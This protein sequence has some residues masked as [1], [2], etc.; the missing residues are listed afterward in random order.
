MTYGDVIKVVATTLGSIASGGVVVLALAGWLG[1]VWANRIM[2]NDRA[3]HARLLEQM[4][5]DAARSLEAQR[6][7]AQLTLHGLKERSD[8][9]VKRLD[10]ELGR[11]RYVHSMQFKKEFELYEQTWAAL[12]LL[13]NKTLSLRPVLDQHD[14]AETREQR[15]ERRLKEF[16]DAFNAFL[17]LVSDHEPFFPEQVFESINALLRA[18]RMEAVDY[19]LR[20][21][22]AWDPQY[23]ERQK[24]NGAEILSLVK[25]IATAIRHRI[26]LLSASR[27]Q[28]P[29]PERDRGPAGDGVPSV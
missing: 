17:T 2:E 4:K 6:H 19:E 25:E 14:P 9:L 13:R 20:T 23:W 7:D 8:V 29:A 10:D 24:K 11:G 21:T 16:A 22:E 3:N 27:M 5:A 18:T 26:G 12:A 28:T 1:R 15:Q